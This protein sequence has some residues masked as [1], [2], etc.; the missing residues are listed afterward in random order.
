MHIQIL[1]KAAQ[2]SGF[3]GG[4]FFGVARAAPAFTDSNT[5][6]NQQVCFNAAF[7]S[8]FYRCGTTMRFPL[9]MYWSENIL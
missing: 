9:R 8:N 3:F 1:Q 4:L 7:S 5:T 2:T 6:Y